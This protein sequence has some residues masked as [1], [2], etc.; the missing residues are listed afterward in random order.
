MTSFLTQ[1]AQPA[2]LI[3]DGATGTELH[4]RGIDTGLPLWSANA[5]L[6]AEG[7]RALR[8]IHLDY[9][10]AGADILTANTFRTHGRTLAKSSHGG[11]A[12]ELTARAVRLAREAIAEH[13]SPAP[14]FVAGSIAPLE[15]CYTPALV[16][17][18]AE[19][20]TEHRQMA[21]HLAEAGADLLLVE[22]MNTIR[23]AVA[24]AEAATTTGLPTLVSFVCS[25]DGRLLSGETIAEAARAVAPL[26]PAAIGVNCAPTHTL[27]AP[28]GELRAAAPH[29]VPLIAYGNIGYADDAQGWVNTDAVDPVAY[30]SYA[31]AWPVHIL[32]GCCG[33]TPEHIRHL[34]TR[35]AR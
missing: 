18:Q 25:A 6:T 10:R 33:T 30:A 26:H 22:T 14:L 17:P 2:R 1:L 29:H 27:A 8:Q 19:C 35:I 5:L 34:R 9:L 13:A 7:R 16:P 32:G 3:L 23:E 28:L 21:E 4:R 24:A 31:T 11:Q 15:D 20:Q 12:R